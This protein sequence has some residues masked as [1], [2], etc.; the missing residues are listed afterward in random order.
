MD[1]NLQ[2][3]KQNLSK[4]ML[5]VLRIRKRERILD[6]LEHITIKKSVVQGNGNDDTFHLKDYLTFC[7]G[8]MAEVFLHE[9]KRTILS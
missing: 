7:L 1:V 6:S 2:Y 5:M 8:V 3:Q 4:M 9:R